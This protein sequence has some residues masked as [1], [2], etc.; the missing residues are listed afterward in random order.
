MT[1]R[2]ITVIA[3]CLLFTAAWLYACA[4]LIRRPV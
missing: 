1:W 3:G 4:C 2:T